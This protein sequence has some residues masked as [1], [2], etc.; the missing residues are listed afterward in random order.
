M[1]TV[2]V[3]GD[4][5]DGIGAKQFGWE[6]ARISALRIT[7]IRQSTQQNRTMIT[8][9]IKNTMKM[10]VA[11]MPRMTMPIQHAHRLQH[12]HHQLQGWAVQ[13]LITDATQR[14]IW[15]INRATAATVS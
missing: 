12:R 3:D 1:V 15:P 14:H 8:A 2:G 4:V 13:V 10:T 11:T 6:G 7:T 5:L 9:R